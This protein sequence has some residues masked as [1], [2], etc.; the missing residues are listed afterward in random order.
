[1]NSLCGLTR[2]PAGA[3][4]TLEKDSPYWI[5]QY[6]HLNRPGKWTKI[7]S[8]SDSE[9]SAPLPRYAHQIVYDNRSKLVYMHGGNA[10]LKDEILVAPNGDWVGVNEPERLHGQAA[11][12][13]HQQTQQSATSEEENRLDD[14]WTLKLRRLVFAF[15]TQSPIRL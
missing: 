8:S 10:G 11:D 13:G 6:K 15:S 3:L 1:M 9:D 7:P 2:G 4:S 12:A 5:Y 14:F